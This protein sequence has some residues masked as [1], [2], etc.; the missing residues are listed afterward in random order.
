T[1]ELDGH[2]QR[3]RRSTV[4]REHHV[5]TAA[6]HVTL[7]EEPRFPDAAGEEVTGASLAPMP[8]AVVTVAVEEGATV[9]AG[10]LLV[11]LEAMKMEHRITATLDGTVTEVRVTPG[12][13]VDADDVLVVVTPPDDGSDDGA[14][15]SS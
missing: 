13:Q 14:D 1:V 11:T 4:G 15:G 12:Q 6:G 10:D 3:V 2:R 5:V 8:G 7:V 9:A